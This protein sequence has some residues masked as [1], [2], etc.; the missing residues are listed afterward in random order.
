MEGIIAFVIW[1][2][3]ALVFVAL[4]IMC[5]KSKEPVG[6]FT[7]VKPPEVTDVKGYNRAVSTLWIVF[8]VLFEA[9]GVP[10]LF[11]GENSAYYIFVMLFIMPLIIGMVIVYLKIEGKYKK[12]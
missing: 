1:S 8:A 11:L 3:V 7:G 4:S 5:Y 2:I 12:K 9:I 6:F 10:L